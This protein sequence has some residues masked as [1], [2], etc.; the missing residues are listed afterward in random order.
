M[1]YIIHAGPNDAARHLILAHGAGAG[2]DSPFMTEIANLLA[3]RGI[4][5]TLFEFAYMAQRRTGGPRRP[6]PKTHVL[7]GEYAGVIKSLSAKRQPGQ[8]LTIGGK[9]LGG[10]VAS[11]IAEVAYKSGNV[12]GLICLGYPFHPP[13]KPEKLR[14]AHLAD[15]TCPSL[16]LQ[17]E[18][19]PF[20][21]RA[22]V[23]AFDLPAA[24]QFHWLS[25][26]DHDFG[27]RGA[28]GFTRKGNLIT[29][30]DTVAEFMQHLK[31]SLKPP[32]D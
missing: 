14:T 31:P 20:G 24:I 11:L 2:I 29:A 25:D 30:A 26:G 18:R 16:I 13:G 5:L 32:C 19:D 17:G 15:L 9:S 10:R 3:A 1:T 27:P 7:A 4:G 22:E 21:N 28:S 23:E 6:P 8:T 12:S